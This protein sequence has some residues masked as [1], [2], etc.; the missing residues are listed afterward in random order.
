MERHADLML[1]N[2]EGQQGP[3]ENS[4]SIDTVQV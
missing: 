1:L 4:H 2:A 3:Y